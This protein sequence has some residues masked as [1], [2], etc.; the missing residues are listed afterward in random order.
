MN[1]AVL[2]GLNTVECLIPTALKSDW[3]TILPDASSWR[4]L[5][6]QSFHVLA[7]PPQARNLDTHCQSSWINGHAWPMWIC[8]I[9]QYAAMRGPDHAEQSVVNRHV[10][11]PT[12]PFQGTKAELLRVAQPP[13]DYCFVG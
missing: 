5:V 6:P 10:Q 11:G 2:L 1:A 4:R 9:S 8:A 12:S 3:S 7:H 13:S